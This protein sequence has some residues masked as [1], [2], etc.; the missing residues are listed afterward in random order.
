MRKRN[1]ALNG[2]WNLKGSAIT[3]PAFECDGTARI[4]SKS[5]C[6]AGRFVATAESEH[7]NS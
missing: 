1:Q 6:A 3:P 5:A 4:G 7:F 2:V